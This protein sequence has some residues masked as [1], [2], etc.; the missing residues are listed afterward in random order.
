[1]PIPFDPYADYSP[2]L[3]HPVF[4]LVGRVADA[5]DLETYVVGGW[6]RDLFLQRPSSD[7][8]IVCVG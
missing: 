3:R 8:D 1:M 2:Y 5:L 6:V 4:A 7:I